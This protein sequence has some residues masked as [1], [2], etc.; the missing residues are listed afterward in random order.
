MKV[1][2]NAFN[3][4]EE[5]KSGK[6]LNSGVQRCQI[7]AICED[8]PES[9]FNL[10]IILEKL[11]LDELSY[12]VAF[13]LKCRNALF[14]I[15]THSGKRACLF[16]EGLAEEESGELR[17]LGRLDYWYNEYVKTGFDKSKMQFCMNVIN[18][19]IL[20]LEEDPDQCLQNFVPPS[21][22][23]LLIGVVSHLGVFLL[24]IWPKFDEWLKEKNVFQRGY[25]GR[26]WDGNNSNLILKHLDS[27]EQIVLQEVPNLGAFVQCLKDF[28]SIKR[29]C[30]G[31][32]LEDGYELCVFSFKNSFL[33]CQEVAQSLGKKLSR[34]WKIHIVIN[35][36]VPFVKHN[37]TGLGQY[38]EQVGESIHAQFKPT[39][40]R[41]KRSESHPEHDQ[42]LLS[43]VKD[44]NKRRMTS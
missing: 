17:T 35:H 32:Q 18:P 31:F 34:T 13:D 33:A 19:R 25:Q 36:V 30:F 5:K 42:R 38:A 39:W 28:R 3:P 22:L 6:F 20:Y 27:L 11:H 14:G 8:I 1:V 21:E 41:F 9:N 23:H 7:L 26:G 43:A 29:S 12:S 24:D 4:N 44:F 2:V 40:K 10:R 37:R 15:S 16:C